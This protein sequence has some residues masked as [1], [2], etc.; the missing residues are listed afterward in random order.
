MVGTAFNAVR[1]AVSDIAASALMPAR[2]NSLFLTALFKRVVRCL[3]SSSTVYSPLGIVKLSR[4]SLGFLALADLSAL[5]KVAGVTLAFNTGFST[6]L[7]ALVIVALTGVFSA[8]L[9]VASATFL[10]TRLAGALGANFATAAGG[11]MDGAV[12]VVGEGTA[13]VLAFS[14]AVV[15]DFFV[16]VMFYS[17]D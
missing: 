6:G 16:A 4:T 12:R 2:I 10:V 11:A 17:F 13:E 14:F 3:S 5:G 1:N 15:V 8:V 7:T 9:V